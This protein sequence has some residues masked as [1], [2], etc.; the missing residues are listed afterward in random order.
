MVME[1]EALS[2]PNLD[3]SC[4]DVAVPT[5]KIA[6]SNS[7]NQD[8]PAGRRVPML[9]A[10][11]VAALFLITAPARA[12]DPAQREF[13]TPQAAVDALIAA[14]KGHDESAVMAVLGP[15]AP[16]ILSSG[17]PVADRNAHE[18]FMHNYEQMHRLAYDQ[19]GRVI[20]Y[21][22][23]DN[24]PMPI[25]L[26]KKGGGWMWD[27]AAGEQELVF[28]RI[29]NN[30]FFTIGVLEDLVEAQRDYYSQPR[31]GS[32]VKQFAQKILSDP[33]KQN[34]LYWKAAADAQQS[35]IGPLIASAAAQ[36][37]ERGAQ[38]QPV[39]FHGYVYKVLTRQGKD[40]KGGARNYLVHGSMTKGFAFLAYPVQYR[41]SGVM[42]FMVNEDG[43]VLQKDLGPD[44][45][46]IA[47]ETT[48]YNPD[49]SWTNAES[50]GAPETAAQP[51]AAGD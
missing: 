32:R 10:M 35:P 28:R 29:G 39:P 38:G 46:K 51:Q 34:G 48:E 11:V 25:P 9:A 16:K 23:A 18:N 50:E 4:G 1:H 7:I 43:V 8:A 2:Q 13:A 6:M 44:T 17:D 3:S 36:G 20:L 30:E 49:K 26:V 14:G 47:M 21:I 41:S 42:T 45:D 40:A 33:G 15:D 27:T 22:G 37:Y 31:Q 5:G 19:Q 24:W 12:E